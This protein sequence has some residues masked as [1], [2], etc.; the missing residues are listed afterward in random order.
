MANLNRFR[1]AIK[2]KEDERDVENFRKRRNLRLPD[3]IIS[4]EKKCGTKALQFF[5]LHHPDII[6][7]NS[8]LQLRGNKNFTAGLIEKNF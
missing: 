5:L 8:E 6:G 7:K 4:G 2:D 3:L 1:Y